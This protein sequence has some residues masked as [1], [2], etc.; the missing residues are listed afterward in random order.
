LLHEAESGE[1]DECR[2]PDIRMQVDIRR[3]A[4]KREKV[5][6]QEA[7]EVPPKGK[8]SANRMRKRRRQRK[9]KTP[10]KGERG[11]NRKWKRRIYGEVEMGAALLQAI[12]SA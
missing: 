2:L 11:A 7:E 3:G 5:Y 6:G 12:A 4:V 1:R 9:K 10:A 8:R